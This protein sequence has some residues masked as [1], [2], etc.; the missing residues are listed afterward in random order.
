MQKLHKPDLKALENAWSTLNEDLLSV[1]GR[2]EGAAAAMKDVYTVADGEGKQRKIK[3]MLVNSDGAPSSPVCK[4]LGGVARETREKIKTSG[5]PSF[6]HIEKALF[7]LNTILSKFETLLKKTKEEIILGSGTNIPSLVNIRDEQ[8]VASYASEY[9]LK[10]SI[11]ASLRWDLP[12][13]TLSTYKVT[14]E[15]QPFL[16]QLL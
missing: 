14:L 3:K 9:E 8:I 2:F 12:E 11:V 16:T 6:L 7:D 10:E 15:C 1:L 5:N 4:T 13:D